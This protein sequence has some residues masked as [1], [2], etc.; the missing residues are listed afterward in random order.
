MEPLVPQGSNGRE[1]SRP[2]FSFLLV[3]P[4]YSLYILQVPVWAL[5]RWE[6]ATK[7]HLKETG[8]EGVGKNHLADRDQWWNIVNILMKNL[9]VFFKCKEILYMLGNC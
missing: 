5:C 6:N 9:Q 7:M 8:Q 4:L 2:E 1:L 3:E